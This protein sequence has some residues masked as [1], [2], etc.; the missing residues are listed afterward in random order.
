MAQDNAAIV[1]R[2]AEEVIAR[3][4]IERAGVCVGGRGE[5]AGRAGIGGGPCPG[6]R[7]ESGSGSAR[8]SQSSAKDLRRC[9]CRSERKFGEEPTA[10]EGMKTTT[11]P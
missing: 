5:Y 10:G 7:S 3:G 4:E 2:F 8:T 9:V 11:P 6:E 1:R